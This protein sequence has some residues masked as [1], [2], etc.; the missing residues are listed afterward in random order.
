MA[1]MYYFLLTKLET[2]SPSHSES[3]VSSKFILA[4]HSCTDRPYYM[5]LPIMCASNRDPMTFF[6]CGLMSKYILKS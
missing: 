3:K 6:I 1:I 5:L 4:N 2:N